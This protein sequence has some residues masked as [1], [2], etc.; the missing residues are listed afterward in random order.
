MFLV[1]L[2][3][4]YIC[5]LFFSGK[6]FLQKMFCDDQTFWRSRK[7]PKYLFFLGG[8]F[9]E[10]IKNLFF[11][12]FPLVLKSVLPLWSKGGGAKLNIFLPFALGLLCA[13]L[14]FFWHTSA[15]HNM[16]TCLPFN[17]I[18]TTPHPNK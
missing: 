4:L 11:E 12:S 8:G 16:F 18:K 7:I 13:A 5:I 14:V 6:L 2:D 17:C 10:K 15:F 3:L 9:E 1:H